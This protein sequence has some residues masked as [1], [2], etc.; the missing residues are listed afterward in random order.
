MTTNAQLASQITDLLARWNAREG[1]LRDWLGGTVTGGPNGD[2]KYPLTNAS[3]ETYLVESPA[4][5]ASTVTGPSADAE[6]SKVAAE[7]A[8]DDSASS[9]AASAA[10][11][12]DSEAHKLSSRQWR[13]EAEVFRNEAAASNASS[14]SALSTVIAARDQT[15]AAR[16]VVLPA[17]DD[18]V[19]AQGRA[20]QAAEAAL[21]SRDQAAAFAASINPAI[22]ATK[23]ELASEIDAI[24][25]AAPGALDTLAE[26]ASAL[27]NNPNFAT[28]MTNALAG[29][30]ALVH[31]HV[32]ADITGLDTLLA[33]KAPVSHGHTTADISGLDTLLAGKAAVSHGHAMAD[34]SGLAAALAAKADGTHTHTALYVPDTRDVNDVPQD[35][36][37]HFVA[38]D[39]KNRA[40]VSN[41][42]VGASGTYAHIMTVA[43]WNTYEGSGGWPTQWSFGDGLAYRQ[44][45]SATTW[46]SWR[47]MW[48]SG[49]FDPASKATLAADVTFRD[50]YAARAD[51]T[52]VYYFGN[53]ARY[54]YWT[55]A[56]FLLAGG[57]L[58]VTNGNVN[59]D[60]FSSRAGEGVRLSN[61]GGPYMSF[62]NGAN[63]TRYGYLK[64]T[65]SETYLWRDVPGTF[66]IGGGNTT[67]WL[68]APTSV[69]YS[70]EVH[71]GAAHFKVGQYHTTLSAG[72]YPGSTQG[73][74]AR[75]FAIKG[76]TPDANGGFMSCYGEG[77]TP[78]SLRL[79]VGNV[80]NA[81]TQTNALEITSSVMKWAGCPVIRHGAA[82][83]SSVVTIST[84]APSGGADGDIWFRV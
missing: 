2:G 43:G 66:T 9:A 1:Q 12:A 60:Q 22:L 15:L 40:A 34:I 72:T 71:P 21:V 25:G 53:G 74:W 73:A 58:D 33:G 28:T 19:E 7:D 57:T 67:I 59:A 48:H 70:F 77:A 50:I 18:T 3:G 5:L 61:D 4:L 55:G 11:A 37:N 64:F 29:K 41:P 63:T 27:G 75:A 69:G 30:A 10:S 84:A 81:H 32:P 79:G 56:Q 65:G 80:D 82:R 39:F 52:G 31:T 46:G 68:G 23:A 35:R 24:L 20:L 45:T 26:L 38:F 62:F 76:G 14:G 13:D 47:S 36:A 17:R 8:R 49:N 6:A 54:L 83:A 44:A 16:D 78:V 42:P 51:G